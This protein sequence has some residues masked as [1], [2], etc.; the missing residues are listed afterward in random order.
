[1]LNIFVPTDYS[2]VAKNAML[3]AVNFALQTESSLILY[4]AMPAII[5]VTEIPYEN[6][7]LDE[8]DETRVLKESF[9]NFLSKNNIDAR[10]LKAS[11]KVNTVIS[12]T[13]SIEEEAENQNADLIVMGTH[14]ATGW[15]RFLLGTNTSKLL[16]KA[17][18][19]VLAIPQNFKFG[20]IYHI[21]YASDL[22]NI[23]EELA[24]ITPYAKLFHAVLEILYFDYAFHSSEANILKADNAI[25]SN[26]YKNIKLSIKKGN[27]EK[28]LADQI[29]NHLSTSSTQT[30]V[31]FREEHGFFDN[32]VMGSNSQQVVLKS[33][34]PVLVVP[35]LNS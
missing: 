26:P 11:F 20:P 29:L 34:I 13:D 8:Q 1:M 2:P 24:I 10:S 14:G 4:H 17:H 22:N 15:R 21:A 9:Y 5:P 33:G 25:K 23:E 16:S 31:M 19:P 3:Y 35:R 12:I 32:I 30:V 18:I 7:Y 28:N 27:I 6:Y